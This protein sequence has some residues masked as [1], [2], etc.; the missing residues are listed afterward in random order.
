MTRYCGRDFTPKEIEQIRSL[1]KQN[2]EFNRMR[3][4]K[5]VCRMLG[6]LKPDGKLKDMSCRVAMLRMQK[7]GLIVLPPPTHAKVRLKKIKFTPA[8]NP[9]SPVVCSVDQLPQLHL[10]MVTK[11]TSALWN[12]Y[13][14]RYHYLG[15]TTLPGAQLR[16]FIAAGKQI[17]ALTGFGAAA[18]QT[19][20]RDQFIGWN[21]NQRKK[22]LN[23]IVNNARFLI[24]PW[25][26]SKNLASKIL[27]LTARRLPDDWVEKYNIRP[28]LMETFVQ[29]N[30]FAGTC[31]K[32]ANWIN[33][34]QT[35]G[36]GKLG[37]PG[38]I[39]VPIKD[40]WVYPIDRKFKALLK[41]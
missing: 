18:W 12:E 8:T 22:N 36:R 34:G 30:R 5:E 40:V 38:K 14:E 35:K 39:S 19:A 10:Q 15:Y 9:Q 13:I 26:Q 4:S 3:L 24:L 33:V 6:W 17:V 1:I 16:Y 23:L 37:P 25:I 41:N 2:P 31:Y 21:H 27:S 32:A 11:A 7:D 20:P 29:K 28:V